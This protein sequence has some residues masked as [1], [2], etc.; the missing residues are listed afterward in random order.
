MNVETAYILSPS[1]AQSY[2]IAVF[3]RRY[4]PDAN[5]IGITFDD[6][7]TFN[8]RGVCP[9]F[10]PL[11]HLELE[12]ANGIVIPTGSESTK[13]LLE[14]GD[15]TI[16]SVTL[17]QP[18]LRVYDK[19]WIIARASEI[20]IPT[21]TTWE[22]MTDVTAYPVFYKQRYEQG[23]G[24]R[25]IARAESEIPLEGRDDLIFQELIGGQGTYGVGFLAEEGQLVA[26]HTHFERESVPRAGGSAVII[27]RFE[28]R[29]L[30]EYTRR[31]IAS[32]GYSG[33]GLTE[34]KYHPDQGD[35]VFMEINAKFWAS[36]EFSF[37]NEHLFL[38]LLFGIDSREEPVERMVF[39]DR[40]FS[41]GLWFV[42]SNL[43]YLIHGST[44]RIYPGWLRRVAAGVIPPSMH[45]ILKRLFASRRK[46]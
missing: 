16:G 21:P 25:G 18:A 28:D 23:G 31:L 22:E 37:T 42:L 5:V 8:C 34:F 6:E 2:A 24:P 33:W 13:Y 26:T 9:R 27:E 43:R 1:S 15:V 35:F 10:I 30:I 19:P 39:M 32:L 45:Q 44:L 40:A 20:G 4:C 41:R 3:L 11:S 38:K 29:R 36:C 17:T 12:D 14:K 46:H 7:L